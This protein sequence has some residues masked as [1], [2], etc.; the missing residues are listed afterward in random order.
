[1]S[2]I[3][4]RIKEFTQSGD[5][6]RQC[7]AAVYR[8]NTPQ[9]ATWC[10]E[11][12]AAKIELLNKKRQEIETLSKANL[13][14]EGSVERAALYTLVD[15]VRPGARKQ[16]LVR[17]AAIPERRNTTVSSHHSL[18]ADAFSPKSDPAHVQ[19]ARRQLIQLTEDV[20]EDFRLEGH[21]YYAN[22]EFD[23]ALAAYQEGLQYVTKE[24]MPTLWATLMIDIGNTQRQR[25]I[26]SK[27]EAIHQNLRTAAVALRDACTVYSRKDFPEL[28]AKIQ[29]NLGQALQE[30]GERTSGPEGI[31]LLHEADEAYR[32]AQ[33]VSMDT[34]P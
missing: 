33:S 10:R 11:G 2:Q 4:K 5:Q 32:K 21:T 7:L 29:N 17:S 20:V 27:E 18:V 9:A 12:A 1:L 24:D 25:A 6:R 8:K 13:Q 22:Y 19:N 26:R 30:Q 23:Q 15:D 14:S 31:K 3:E 34:P 16:F 28:W